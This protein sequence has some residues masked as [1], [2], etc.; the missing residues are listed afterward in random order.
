MDQAKLNSV[1]RVLTGLNRRL[2][3]LLGE[4]MTR[5]DD[6]NW[7]EHKHPRDSDGKFSS[8]GGGGTKGAA[9]GSYKSKLAGKKGSVSS[10]IKHMLMAGVPENDVFAA[11]HEMYG[12][13]H[14]KFGYVKWNHNDLK[15]KGEAVPALIKG[16]QMPP[17]PEPK[18]VEIPKPIPPG[19]P[20]ATPPAPSPAPYGAQQGAKSKLIMKELDDHLGLIGGVAKTKIEEGLKKVTAALGKPTEVQQLSYLGAIEPITGQGMSK[21][22]NMF[23]NY[24]A[25]LKSEYGLNG[26]AAKPPADDL[27]NFKLNEPPKAPEP[28]DTAAK[29]SQVSKGMLSDVVKWLPK[30]SPSFQPPV[31]DLVDQINYALGQTTLEKQTSMLAQ[32]PMIKNPQGMGQAGANDALAALQNDYGVGPANKPAEAAKPKPVPP[33]VEAAI[34]HAAKAAPMKRVDQVSYFENHEGKEVKA[35]LK[36]NTKNIP[37][38]H[39]AKVTAA[40]G[41]STDGMSE[42]VDKAMQAYAKDTLGTHSTA[43]MQAIADYRDG[44]YTNINKYMLGEKD[45]GK[46]VLER[47]AKIK[48]ALSNS[49]VPADTPMF[50]GLS[51][52][53]KDLSGF[54]DPQEAV[55]RCFE[56]K[57]F[58]SASRSESQARAFGERTVLHFTVPAGSPGVVMGGQSYSDDPPREREILLDSN[59]MFRV[60]KVEQKVIGNNTRH[61]V[62]CTYL[63]KREDE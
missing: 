54:D 2:G 1:A 37:G 48:E 17:K 62:H 22:C 44:Y 32:I 40:Y 27:A 24:L 57:N 23:N 15:K 31:K 12:L 14:D 60:D 43:Q 16:G 52:S 4:P 25:T 42:S 21:G 59:I 36:V 26:E 45:P 20:A 47:V 11:A 35:R 7:E 19:A 56:H 5:A 34:F 8:G 53:L 18:P 30:V 28:A 51:C 46:A 50:R 6:A 55:G 38:D 29:A 9:L 49:Y 10:L 3:T 41:N 63:G 33:K 39:Y 61:V 58:A 13:E